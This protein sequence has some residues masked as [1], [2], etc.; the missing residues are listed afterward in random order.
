MELN[1]EAKRGRIF[2]LGDGG[3]NDPLEKSSQPRRLP[4]PF[5]L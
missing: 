3:F 1:V 4:F 5:Y 2:I